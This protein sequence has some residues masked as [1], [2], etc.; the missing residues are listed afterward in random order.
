MSASERKIAELEA[1]VRELEHLLSRQLHS[2]DALWM[3]SGVSAR[4]GE[5]FVHLRWGDESGQLSANQA[6]EHAMSV[7]EAAGGAEFDAAFV[8]WARAELNLDH[9][10]AVL[11][12][13]ELRKHRSGGDTASVVVEAPA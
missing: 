13:A 7:L 10:R 9:E 6:R 4:T 12:L 2:G 8:K 1:K 11:V 5:P 3:E